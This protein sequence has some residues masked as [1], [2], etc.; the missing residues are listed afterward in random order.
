MCE[1]LTQYVTPNNF[2][3]E[4]KNKKEKRGFLIFGNQPLP[5]NWV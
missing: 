3:K 4:I 5:K 2:L 1:Y